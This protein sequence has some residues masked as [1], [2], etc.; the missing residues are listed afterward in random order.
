MKGFASA[1]VAIALT[2]PGFA[3]ETT[4]VAPKILRSFAL[5]G[6]DP[7]IARAEL[8]RFGTTTSAAHL[9][10]IVAE[11][12]PSYG[13]ATNLRPLQMGPQGL[14]SML[15]QFKD[16]RAIAV[17]VRAGESDNLAGPH[18]C[19]IFMDSSKGTPKSQDFGK[20][21]HWCA[22]AITVGNID[23]SAFSP[24]AR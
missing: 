19:R 3:Q 14:T 24:N 17:M 15:Y 6:V 12:I 18:G 7:Q 9:V 8:V 1:L 2:T 16:K 10:G 11:F 22:N 20:I 13:Q 5:P 21:V 4:I 23:P